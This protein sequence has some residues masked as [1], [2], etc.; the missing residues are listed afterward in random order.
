ME[1]KFKIHN[2]ETSRSIKLYLYIA[3]VV[4]E[5]SSTCPP[6]CPLTHSYVSSYINTFLYII[7]VEVLFARMLMFQ[8]VEKLFDVLYLL[9]SVL[10]KMVVVTEL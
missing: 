6:R 1:T 3:D 7:Y 5:M 9:L 2:L 10:W 8:G 4:S